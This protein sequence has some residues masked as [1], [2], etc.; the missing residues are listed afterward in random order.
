M[1]SSKYFNSNH[2]EF[3]G[4]GT[5]DKLIQTSGKGNRITNK[6]NKQ[7]ITKTHTNNIFPTSTL[8]FGCNPHNDN[9]DILP[10]YLV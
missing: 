5:C 10:E 4:Y 1:Y 2:M 9:S 3:V 7:G 6:M 8:G